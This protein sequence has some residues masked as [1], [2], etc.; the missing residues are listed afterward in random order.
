MRKAK[1]PYWSEDLR[2]SVGKFT[3]QGKHYEWVLLAEI[4]KLFAYVDLFQ[5]I[6]FQ[7]FFFSWTLR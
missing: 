1:Y 2:L 3:L 5:Q 7:C 6:Y 4:T